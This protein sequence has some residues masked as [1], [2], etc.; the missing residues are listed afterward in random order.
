LLNAAERM[1]RD[2]HEIPLVWT[3]RAE[4][5]YDAGP[6]DF[7]ALASAVGADIFEDLRLNSPEGINRLRGARCDIAISVN[8]LS[9]IGQEAID[10]FPL[11]ILNAH[12]GDLPRYRGNA[13]TN[14]AILNGE[15]HIGLCIHK[16]A[17]E[18][19]AGPIVV[20]DRF[21]LGPDTYVGEVHSWLGQRIPELFAEAVDGLAAG[22]LE[23]QPQS[24]HPADILRCYPRRPE[25]SRIN[26][27]LPVERIYRL[28]R[29]SSRPFGGA[30]TSMEGDRRV[31]IWR[32]QP[33]G[34]IEPFL[35]IPGQV[36]GSTDLDPL[37]ACGDGMLRL[38][39]IEIDG[40][41][42]S[43]EAKRFVRKSL[44]TRLI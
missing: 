20:R 19:D 7:K 36:C 12:A 14:W 38:T 34:S 25:D 41:A 35:A 23:P 15:Q 16:M 42:D 43:D 30:F 33:A 26:W 10:S 9:L 28:V 4:Q 11:G 6:A 21:L 37:I 5:Y 24:S 1:R 27:S 44:R 3:C 31:T 22:R 8:W 13:T 2:G 29:A 40:I 39:Q 32:A 18:L 17:V